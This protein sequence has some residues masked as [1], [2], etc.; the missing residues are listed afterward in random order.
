VFFQVV[1]GR[2]VFDERVTVGEG[3]HD[4]Q[5]VRFGGLVG[6]D[7]HEHLPVHLQSGLAPC[8]RHLYVR[9]GAGDSL[10][11]CER[12]PAAFIAVPFAR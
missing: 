6:R 7:A 4:N 2:V 11:R 8:G 9:K 3:H 10:D 12:L 1:G 5:R